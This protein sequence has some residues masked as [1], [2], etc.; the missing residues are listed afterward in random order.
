MSA[1]KKAVAQVKEW[2]TLNQVTATSDV[3]FHKCCSVAHRL[4]I[5]PKSMEVWEEIKRSASGATTS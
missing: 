1:F 5:Y 3:A 2:L 4:G